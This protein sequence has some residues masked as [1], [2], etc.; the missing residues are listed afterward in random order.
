MVRNRPRGEG[1]TSIGGWGLGDQGDD[2]KERNEDVR[3][4]LASI[5]EATLRHVQA[6]LSAQERR[7]E[8]SQGLSVHTREGG[9]VLIEG[10]R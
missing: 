2:K 5:L 4:M 3:V 8:R 9:E 10:R 6:P 1:H 7:C